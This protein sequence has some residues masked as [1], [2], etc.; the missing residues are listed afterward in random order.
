MADEL[1]KFEDTQD[2]PLPKFEDTVE[3][4]QGPVGTSA[5]QDAAYGTGLKSLEGATMGAIKP[6]IAYGMSTPEMLTAMKNSVP[7]TEHYGEDAGVGNAIAKNSRAVQEHFNKY[8]EA[9]GIPGTVAEGVAGLLAGPGEIEAVKGLLGAGK[10]VGNVSYL[11]KI[12]DQVNN[13]KA[14]KLAGFGKAVGS[15]ALEGGGVGGTVAAI[16][17]PGS[18]AE[19]PQ[20]VLHAGIKGAEVGAGTGA[21]LSGAGNILGNTAVAENMKNAFN[22]G[23]NGES[24]Y[25][26]VAATKAQDANMNA[27]ENVTNNIT[28]N[29]KTI[30]NL[31]NAELKRAGDAGVTVQPNIDLLKRSQ[32]I[33]NTP[34]MGR[35]VAQYHKD[36][37]NGVLSPQ[38]A[39]NYEMLVREMYQKARNSPLPN[40]DL[41]T[42]LKDL[43]GNLK[44]AYSATLPADRANDLNKLYSTNKQVQATFMN[45]G[46]RNPKMQLEDVGDPAE[47]NEKLMHD[48]IPNVMRYNPAPSSQAISA[49]KGY[50]NHANEAQNELNQVLENIRQKEGNGPL[51]D[52]YNKAKI[53]YK[54]PES[55]NAIQNAGSDIVT[56]GAASGPF[57]GESQVGKNVKNAA[58]IAT[59]GAGSLM[60]TFTSA[61]YGI[62]NIAGKL[63]QPAKYINNPVINNAAA[64][65]NPTNSATNAA[66]MKIMQ[67]HTARKMLGVDN[68]GNT[69]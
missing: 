3:H 14:N 52:M 50:T 23:V 55:L 66:L 1:P 40:P 54:I 5:M 6:A 39:K 33:A 56:S 59:G 26:K 63:T 58:N 32:E 36:L 45:N 25:G 31:Y 28:G 42:S 29:D 8:G 41:E 64:I 16:N 15:G 2:M 34:G 7:G 18:L 12:L 67:N 19:N 48:I 10:E 62:S 9:A 47:V 49:I 51:A 37:V 46:I 43:Q 68:E 38:D 60:N 20:D 22:K 24:S 11:Q 57:R 4:P 65:A 61:P 17:T 30:S 13:I 35:T 27:A 69:Q 53:D 44:Q 21:V